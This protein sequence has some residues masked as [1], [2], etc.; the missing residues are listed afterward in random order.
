LSPAVFRERKGGGRAIA[1]ASGVHYQTQGRLHRFKAAPPGD[2][3]MN[4]ILKRTEP[5]RVAFMRHVG[6]YDQVA[7]VWEQ[8]TMFLGRHG[9]IG[10]D[11]RFVGI[12]HD[13]PAVTPS[14][15]IRYDAC[16]TVGQDFRAQ[17]EIGVQTIPGGDYAVMTH[18]GPYQKLGVSYGRLLGQWLPRSGRELRS[19]P[20]FEVYFNSP[21]NTEPED[22]VT[23]LY[24]PLA[25]I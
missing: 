9:L 16:V 19:T 2:Q 20:C 17:G 13:D 12:C 7:G 11:S 25:T 10:G 21:E 8:L 15:R 24:A 22:L 5:L 18:F 1:A 14:G 4:V 3:N 23:D 6:P